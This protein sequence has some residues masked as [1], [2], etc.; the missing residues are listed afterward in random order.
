MR[1]IKAP[2]SLNDGNP[3]APLWSDRVR[4]RAQRLSD[5][6]A[7]EILD[8]RLVL[9]AAG[10]IPPKYHFLR[11]FKSLQKISHT[12]RT[13]TSNVVFSFLNKTVRS[14]VLQTSQLPSIA[15]PLTVPVLP[16]PTASV[17]LSPRRGIFYG[18]LPL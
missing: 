2:S 11:L 8:I 17:T 10:L 12:L 6:S 9:A 5:G 16:V 13:K 14:L 18:W 4:P 7:P 1:K 3:T 15:F